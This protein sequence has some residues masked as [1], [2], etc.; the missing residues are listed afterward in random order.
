MVVNV[1]WR[2]RR[3]RRRR[4]GRRRRRKRRKKRR[5]IGNLDRGQG[6]ALCK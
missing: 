6:R 5:P 2:R 4:K 3:R 1:L